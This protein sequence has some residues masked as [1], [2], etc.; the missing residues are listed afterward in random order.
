M[1]HADFVFAAYAVTAVVW[2]G[3]IVDTL[4]R[5]WQHKK[6]ARHD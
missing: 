1:T 5:L 4:W 6:Q 3:L 2:L